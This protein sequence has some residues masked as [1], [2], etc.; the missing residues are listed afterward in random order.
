MEQNNA[1]AQ[2]PSGLKVISILSYI[3]N[4]FWALISL[5]FIVASGWIMGMIG[6]G[7]AA[8]QTTLTNTEGMD[9]ESVAAINKGA[10][11]V[12]GALAMGTGMLIGAG[13]LLLLLNVVAILG[14][15]R[16]SKL[17]KSGFILYVIPSVLWAAMLI[18]AGATIPGNMMALISGVLTLVFVGLF[19][20]NLKYMR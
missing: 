6:G 4:G 3:G 2:A 1:P 10:S 7:V 5:L 15:A 17:K 14:V 19:G 18:Y 11:E 9:A 16:M 8:A 20:M 12:G 13:V